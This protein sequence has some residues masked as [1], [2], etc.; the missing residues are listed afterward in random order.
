MT[1]RAA[2][3]PPELLAPP[4]EGSA[5]AGVPGVTHYETQ[6]DSITWHKIWD[7]ELE[8]LTNVSRPIVLALSTMFIGSGVGLLPTVLG[9][10]DK[11]SSK[12][13]LTTTDLQ[14]LLVA[15]GCWAFGL[16]FGFFAARGQYDAYRTKKAI[17]ARNPHKIN[18]TTGGVPGA[19]A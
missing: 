10:F 12:M 1:G 8:S 13:H 9:V 3:A 18:Q 5:T 15:G 7:Y 11:V 19:S 2:K 17:R 14:M 16:A 4:P 6:P